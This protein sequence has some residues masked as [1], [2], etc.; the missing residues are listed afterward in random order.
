MIFPDP[1]VAVRSLAPV[2][3]PVNVIL[4]PRPEEFVVI[5][6]FAPKSVVP[7]ETLPLFVVIEEVPFMPRAPIATEDAAFETTISPFSVVFPAVVS[8]P[9][10]KVFVLEPAKTTPPVFR[11]VAA[12]VMLEPALKVIPYPSEAVTRD[13][14]VASPLKVISPVVFIRVTVEAA[15]S[16]EIVVLLLFKRVIASTD[17]LDNNETFAPPAFRVRV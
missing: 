12:S 11:N 5:D 2:S 6:K 15:T 7:K 10:T 16:P 4:F 17:T 3:G 13:V 9:F 1:A 8:T 14:I